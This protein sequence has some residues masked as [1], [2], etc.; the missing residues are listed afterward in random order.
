MSISKK[1]V[2]TVVLISLGCFAVSA[3]NA[4]RSYYVSANGN[5]EN[6]GRSEEAPFKGA[7]KYLV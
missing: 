7:P 3:Q 2:L 4:P 5:D 6:N 1:L